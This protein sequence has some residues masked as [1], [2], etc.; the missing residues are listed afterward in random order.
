MKKV[1]AAINLI[2]IQHKIL[3]ISRKKNLNDFNLPGGGVEK[4]EIPLQAAVRELKEE[5]GLTATSADF[6]YKRII[7]P[8]GKEVHTFR[9]N[10]FEGE[11]KNQP[12]E[13]IIKLLSPDE[14][15]QST[16]T[17]HQYNIDLLRH[18]NLI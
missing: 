3:T 17:Y 1:L 15:C 18:L 13:G 16:N 14:L 5:V 11:P 10:S 4:N 6:V 2:I 12:G 7:Q 9:I 8:S